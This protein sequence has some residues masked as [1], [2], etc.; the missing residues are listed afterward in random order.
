MN[1]FETNHI[2]THRYFKKCYRFLNQ[3]EV[4]MFIGACK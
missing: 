2:E 4:M 3:V 1:S